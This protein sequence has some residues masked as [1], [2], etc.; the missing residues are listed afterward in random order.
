MSGR[1]MKRP[2]SAKRHIKYET[3]SQFVSAS[4]LRRVQDLLDDGNGAGTK[5]S[6]GID[7]V[8]CISGIDGR[9]NEGCYEL[10]NYLLFGFFEVRKAELEKSGF[11]EEVIDDLMIVIRKTRV[12][13]Y[14]NPIN[15]HYFLPYTSHWTNVTFHCLQEE[16]YDLDT[17]EEAEAAEEFKVQSLIAM[18][19]GCQRIGVPY[20]SFTSEP[21]ERKFDK[22]LLEKWPIIQAFALEDFGGGGFFTL[23]FDVSDI[24]QAIHQLHSYQ[25]PVTMEILTT[26]KLPM[27]ERQWRNMTDS[28]NMEIANFNGVLT[29][30]RI[31]EPLRSFYQHGR[32]GNHVQD[33]GKIRMP[34][35]LFGRNSSQMTI[36]AVES[37]DTPPPGDINLAD[38]DT[39]R[40]MVCQVMSPRSPITCTRTYFV[41]RLFTVDT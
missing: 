39:V 6:T 38:T 22:M 21:G 37:G 3:F 30:E 27:L 34:Y 15:W 25:D 23:K 28:V 18:T 40:H 20:Y 31:A 32:V 2:S 41:S 11:P 33:S 4:R 19:S 14:C 26:E 1:L 10:I 7:A 8:L 16:E 36:E 24:S 13:V 17:D 35:V 12:D 29:Q 5:Q 9:Y